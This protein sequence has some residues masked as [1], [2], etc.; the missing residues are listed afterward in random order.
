MLGSGWVWPITFWFGYDGMF[1]S[2][3]TYQ[4]LRPPNRA[5]MGFGL[6]QLGSR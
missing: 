4:C 1:H 2:M 3:D 5:E 6:A